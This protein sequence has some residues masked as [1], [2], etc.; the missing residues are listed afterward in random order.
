MSTF[1]PNLFLTAI[2]FLAFYLLCNIYDFLWLLIPNMAKFSKIMSEY[3][4]SVDPGDLGGLNR[5]YY[6]YRD[7]KLLLNLLWADHVLEFWP[8]LNHLRLIQSKEYTQ[9]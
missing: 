6:D 7:F 8:C 9:S 5:V 1:T 4:T 3:R 2:F